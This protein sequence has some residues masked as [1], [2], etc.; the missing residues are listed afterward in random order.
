MILL[1]KTVFI[2]ETMSLLGPAKDKFTAYGVIITTFLVM[3][4]FLLSEYTVSSVNKKLLVLVS[5]TYRQL[6]HYCSFTR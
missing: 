4:L 6:F 1:I 5:R 3:A 2:E